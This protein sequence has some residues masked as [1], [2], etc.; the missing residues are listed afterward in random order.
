LGTVAPS[1]PVVLAAPLVVVGLAE[2]LPACVILALS[3]QL[4]FLALATPLQDHQA[5]VVEVRAQELASLDLVLAQL[6]S[7]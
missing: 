3:P 6:R 2:E 5:E 7:S 4:W 1:R